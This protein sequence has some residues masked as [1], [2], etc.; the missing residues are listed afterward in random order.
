MP[1]IV[2]VGGG[3]AGRVGV[4]LHDCACSML[5]PHL[6]V[7]LLLSPW[8]HHTHTMTQTPTR[9]CTPQA[10]TDY[11]NGMLQLAGDNVWEDESEL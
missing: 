11:Q 5:T 6:P 4:I 2:W 3:W 1:D 8:L 9:M 7:F 10:F